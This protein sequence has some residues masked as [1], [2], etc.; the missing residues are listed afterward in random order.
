M[1]DALFA[2]FVL[3]NKSTYRTAWAVPPHVSLL[4][5]VWARLS[6]QAAEK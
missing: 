2:A 3:K 5:L 1:F 4:I 6:C